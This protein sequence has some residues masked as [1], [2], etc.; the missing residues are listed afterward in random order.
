MSKV[1][2]AIT[3]PATKA[4]K[5]ENSTMS[6]R[7]VRIRASPF[8]SSVRAVRHPQKYGRSSPRTQ[9]HENWQSVP[10]PPRP[11]AALLLLQSLR[12]CFEA[13]WT[14]LC[15]DEDE[16]SEERAWDSA[17]YAETCADI[18]GVK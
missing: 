5:Q 15:R 4:T 12:C 18:S 9:N 7:S 8:T 11:R 10:I 16:G 2:A 14:F 13:Q 6:R 17:H 3:S 1:A